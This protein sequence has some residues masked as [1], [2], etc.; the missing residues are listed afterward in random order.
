MACRIAILS[1]LIVLASF[2]GVSLAS[3]AAPAPPP[4]APTPAPPSPPDNYVLGAGDQIEVNVFGEPDLSRTVTIKP[5]GVVALP[6]INQVKAG[7]KTAAQ[8]EVELTK[9][10]ARFLRAPSVSVIV[11]QFRMHRVYVMGEVAKPGR[12]DLTD[13]MTVL[14]ALTAAGGATDKGNLDG[15]QLARVENGKS[16]SI[17]IKMSQVIQGKDPVQNVKLQNGDLLYVPR[18]GMNFMEIL[19]NIGVLRMILGLF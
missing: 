10:Y 1:G 5:D 4:A 9:L 11:R 13:D 14:D 7:G 16:K 2:G 18:R 17:P 12:Y 19:Q 3:T 6:L 8:L 15:M